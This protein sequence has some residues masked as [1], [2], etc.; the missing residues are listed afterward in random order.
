VKTKNFLVFQ[1]GVPQSPRVSLNK[2]AVL[3]NLLPSTRKQKENRN[4][5]QPLLLVLR[6]GEASKTELKQ[7]GLRHFAKDG[8]ADIIFSTSK[9]HPYLQDELILDRFLTK[10]YHID[11]AIEDNT[12]T[13]N[14][15]R[16][17]EL[18]EKSKKF[19]MR[20]SK[21]CALSPWK[22]R[23]SVYQCLITTWSNF[24]QRPELVAREAQI[25]HATRKMNNATKSKEELASVERAADRAQVRSITKLRTPL[26][27]LL[28]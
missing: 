19:P 7:I 24:Y 15:I 12:H 6:K 5:R 18:Y 23:Y 2:S 4:H 1:G 21:L 9:P 3:W 22:E 11:L 8:C 14:I 17:L 27:D 28:F 20:K 25:L 10:L 16:N 13:R 26:F